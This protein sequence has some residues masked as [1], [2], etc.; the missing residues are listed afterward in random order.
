MRIL[1]IIAILTILSVGIQ[2]KHLYSGMD[3]SVVPL[4]R[5]NWSNQVVKGRTNDE[6]IIV[7]F[8]KSG[9]GQSYDFGLNFSKQADKTK[10][11]FKWAG[12]DCGVDSAIC[13]KEGVTTFPTVKIYPPIPIPPFVPEEA[14]LDAKKIAA[15]A[16]GYVPNNVK[17]VTDDNMNGILNSNP[18]VPKV[19]LLSNKDKIPLLWKAISNS[20]KVSNLFRIDQK[21]SFSRENFLF[22]LIFQK[23][24][25]NTGNRK[26]TLF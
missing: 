25:L 21:C 20:F 14:G 24:P 12:I 18:S 3:G 7:H 9:D 26:L 4:S 11:I 15:W 13:N 8:F 19:L 1:S 16:S 10:G 22:D 5:S 2:T 6:V 23:F 17:R